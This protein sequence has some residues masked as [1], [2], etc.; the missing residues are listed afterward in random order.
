MRWGGMLACAA[1]RAFAAS[2]LEQRTNV[3]GVDNP[4]LITDVLSELR[5]AGLD[6]FEG[7]L[8]CVI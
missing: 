5:H 2:W 3:G 4:P 1:A 6:Q 7:F 8:I